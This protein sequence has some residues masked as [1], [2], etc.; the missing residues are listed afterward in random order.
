[1][2]VST[3][4]AGTGPLVVAGV[5]DSD[6]GRHA[7]RWAA[8][9]ADRRH[10][11]L[12][13]VHAYALPAAGYSGYNPFPAD[14]LSTLEED[15]RDTLNGLAGELQRDHPRIS[16]GTFVTYG[17]AVTVLRSAASGAALAVV[18]GHRTSRVAMALGSVAGRFAAGTHVPVAVVHSADPPDTGS[19]V[20][21]VDGSPAGEPAIGF[22]FEEADL[23]GVPLIAMHTWTSPVAPTPVPAYS[24]AMVDEEPIEQAERALLSERL[25]GWSQKYPDVTVEQVLVRGAPAKAI[26]QRARTAQLVVVG[27]RWHTALSALLLGSTSQALIT[28]SPA[29]V[30]VVGT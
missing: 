3:G 4:V 23:R 17:D 11:R 27:T 10:G 25:A 15:A 28:H 7:A 20:L 9:E 14:L 8:D 6:C 1:M 12:L 2:A 18:G 13:M 24:A 26:L 29:P 16:I 5:D 30:V 22:A 21:G 19:V